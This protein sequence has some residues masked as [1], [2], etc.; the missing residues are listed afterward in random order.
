MEL[1]VELFGIA[2]RR[3]GAPQVRLRFPGDVCRLHDVVVQLTEQFPVLL[4]DAAV[5]DNQLL[6]LIACIDSEQGDRFVRH[7]ESEIHAGERLL[8]MSGDVGG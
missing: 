5:R 3:V 1:Q 8:L 2:R 6:H 4:P 7:L